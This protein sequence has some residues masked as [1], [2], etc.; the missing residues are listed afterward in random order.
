M[1]NMIQNVKDR[2]NNG[3]EW[4]EE[5]LGAILEILGGQKAAAEKKVGSTPPYFLPTRL[6]DP[7]RRRTTLPTRLRA[8][9]TRRATR[10]LLLRQA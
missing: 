6:T 3:V 4:S 5:K 7:S 8:M 9:P 1:E 2:I 10:P